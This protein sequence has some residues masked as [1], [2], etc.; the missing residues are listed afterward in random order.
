MH[1]R[2]TPSTC[3]TYFLV[4]NSTLLMSPTSMFGTKDEMLP[5]WPSLSTSPIVSL[6]GW[7]TLAH[8]AFETNRELFSPAPFFPPYVTQKACPHCFDP[9]AQLDGLLALHLRR[10]DFLEHCPNLCHWGAN[11]NAFNRFPEFPDQW[12]SP[13]GSEEYRMSVYLKS[14]LPNIDQIVEKIEGIRNTAAGQGL[15]NIYIMTNGDREWLQDLKWALR[16]AYPWL[17]IATSRDMV[18][19]WEQKHV[20]QTMDMLIGQRAQV[21]VGNGVCHFALHSVPVTVFTVLRSFLA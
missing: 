18:L 14:C 12:E 8:R 6:L 11:W 2:E 9:Y 15:K 3:C 10:G 19:T 1:I 21:F 5:V 4:L 17:R 7:S 16:R 13:Q 20:S